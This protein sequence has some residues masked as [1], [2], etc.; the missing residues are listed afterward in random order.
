MNDIFGC[1]KIL[2][3]AQGL[4]RS[5][6][7]IS[8]TLLSYKFNLIC[9]GQEHSKFLAAAGFVGDEAP[10]TVAALRD[11]TKKFFVFCPSNKGGSQFY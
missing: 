3:K 9:R 6:S 10:V 11:T 7:W 4:L 2:S 8:G 5:C 1:E